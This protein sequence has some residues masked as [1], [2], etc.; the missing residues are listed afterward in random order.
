V[1]VMAPDALIA[2]PA[3]GL[4]VI[5]S[6][7]AT[8][9]PLARAAL[10]AGKAVVVDKPL[11]PDAAQARALAALPG[12][13]RLAVFHNRRWDSDFLTVRDLLGSGRLGRIARAELCWDRFRPAI[14]PGWREVAGDGA[15]L[16][17]DLGP[18]LVDQALQLFGLPDWVSAD[19][20]VQR[21]EA[22]VDDHFQLTLGYGAARVTLAAS[23]LAAEPR[24]RWALHGDRGSFVKGGIDPQE[25]VLR[26]GGSPADPG[27]G[28]EPAETWGTL[29][30]ADGTTVRWPSARGDWRLFYGGVADMLDGG[31]PPVPAADAAAGLAILDL[32]RRSAA[33]ERRLVP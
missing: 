2:D 20:A 17:A 7:N 6:P 33:E 32:A 25:G 28:E 31:P 18:H 27:F 14:K 8:H 12:A 26:A 13:E 5:A 3:I 30:H 10:A 4:V 16:L 11:A 23:S 15:G 24:P 9:V 1:R 19:L 22:A 29:T 21:P